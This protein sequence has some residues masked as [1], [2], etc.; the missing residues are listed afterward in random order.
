MDHLF[1]FA[2]EAGDFAFKRG[3][4][5]SRFY[6]VCTIAMR[7]CDLGHKL[8]DLRRRLAWKDAPLGDYFHASTDRQEIRNAVF[9]I[10][11]KEEFSIQATIMEKSKAQPQVRQNEQRFYQYGWH[12]HFQHSSDAYLN[13]QTTLMITVASIGTKRKRIDFEDAVRDVV[14]Q[15]IPSQQWRTAFWPCQTDPCLQAADYCTCAIQRKWEKADS[16]S[17]DLIRDKINYEYELWARGTTHY[18]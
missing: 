8:I 4:N 6:V 3:P 18:Y 11:A 13:S 10:L 14:R 12:Y 7:S 15:K 16:R 2:D 17:Y 9:A 5:I 1:L